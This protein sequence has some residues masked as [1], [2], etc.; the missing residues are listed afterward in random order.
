MQRVMDGQGGNGSNFPGG[1][2]SNGGAG[3][4]GGYGYF[5]SSTRENRKGE[6]GTGG[7]ITIYANRLINSSNIYSK[8]SAGGIGDGA[9]GGSSGGGS[10]NIFY[11]QEYQGNG[12]IDTSS[13]GTVG[14]GNSIIGGAGG[15]G[16]ISIGQLVE[17]TYKS[18]FS[19]Y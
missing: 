15:T 19:N 12:S 6:N 4:P 14:A 8:G 13:P 16:S 17:G 7:L 5:M 3:N 9:G 10:I 1:Q 2:S 18:T 11:V